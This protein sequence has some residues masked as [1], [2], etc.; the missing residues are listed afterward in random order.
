MYPEKTTEPQTSEML[1]SKMKESYTTITKGYDFWQF[2]SKS[3]FS[4]NG[5]LFLTQHN[6]KLLAGAIIKDNMVTPCFMAKKTWGKIIQGSIKPTLSHEGLTVKIA[7]SYKFIEDNSLTFAIDLNLLFLPKS[8]LK[9][10]LTIPQ[11]DH[12]K[13]KIGF[14]TDY[15]YNLKF[16]F[17]ILEITEFQTNIEETE[18]ISV[19]D[20]N[21]LNID[22][23]SEFLHSSEETNYQ[24]MC[25]GGEAKFSINQHQDFCFKI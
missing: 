13:Y 1:D 11:D 7:T 12:T 18:T 8:K 3:Y 23:Y 6:T 22:Q 2:T 9:V 5:I 4:L 17:D 14:S 15:T 10:Y 21:M 19:Q 25:A 20:S 24:T 16:Y